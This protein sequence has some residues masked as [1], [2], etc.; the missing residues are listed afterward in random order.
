MGLCITHGLLLYVLSQLRLPDLIQ[1]VLSGLGGFSNVVPKGILHHV[2]VALGR[3]LPQD[4]CI[5]NCGQKMA[6]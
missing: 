6:D 5:A 3:L 2:Q 4:V 1:G